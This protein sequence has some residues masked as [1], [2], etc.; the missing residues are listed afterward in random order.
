VGRA[1][2]VKVGNVPAGVWFCYAALREKE[3]TVV[4]FCVWM[5]AGDGSAFVMRGVVIDYECN[6][7]HYC[8][9]L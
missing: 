9:L 5:G 8:T 7:D 2:C 6:K 3:T 1:P 4:G